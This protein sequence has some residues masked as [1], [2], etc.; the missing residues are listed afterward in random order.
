MLNR[1]KTT[2]PN[3]RWYQV[4]GCGAISR[5]WDFP[6]VHLFNQFL[7]EPCVEIHHL[8]TSPEVT[9]RGEYCTTTMCFRTGRVIGIFTEWSGLDICPLFRT[10]MRRY[11]RRKQRRQA[12]TVALAELQILLPE[13]DPF[14]VAYTGSV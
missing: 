9:W 12:V 13:L 4:V 10:A 11:G 14:V 8:L 3:G 1:L 5:S 7:I 6:L 2:Q